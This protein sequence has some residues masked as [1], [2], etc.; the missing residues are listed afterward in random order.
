MKAVVTGASGFVG[1]YLVTHLEALGHEVTGFD[2]EG[3]NSIDVTEPDSVREVLDRIRPDAVFH[4]AA[5]SHVGSSWEA[6]GEVLRVN[7]MGTLAVLRACLDTRVS[8]VI[9]VGSADEYGPVEGVD[10]IDEQAPLR[11]ITPYGVSKACAELLAL[12]SHLADGL[13]V[14]RVR[15]FN[16]TGPGQSD[17][18]LVPALARRVV[19]AER[20]GDNEIRI[21]SVEAVRDLTDVRDVVRAYALLTERGRP[22]EAYNVCRGVGLTVGEIAA[23]LLS[24]ATRPLELVVDPELVRP[25]EVPR[26]VGDPTKLTDDTGWLSEIDPDRTLTDVLDHARSR[27]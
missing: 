21:G 15:A 6:P 20:A 9:V 17:A 25:V 7:V 19:E 16:H 4:L 27:G 1:R 26:L 12:Q 2:R 24:H 13:P 11:P 14:I 8:R 10:R 23:R 5:L 18:F 3:P 22:G